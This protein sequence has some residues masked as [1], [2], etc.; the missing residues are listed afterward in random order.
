MIWSLPS[1][2]ANVI[3]ADRGF[4]PGLAAFGPAYGLPLSALAGVLER[5]FYTRAGIAQG[6]IWY[7]LQ[8][9]FISLIVGY[10][11]LW[12]A[13][14][15]L[16][17]IGPFWLPISVFLSIAVERKYLQ[18]RAR[19]SGFDGGWKWVGWGNVFS[20]VVLVGVLLLSTPFDTFQNRLALYPYRNLL[21]GTGI[22]VSAGIFVAAFVGPPVARRLKKR[23]RQ[24]TA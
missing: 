22:A 14:I 3:T 6:A 18:W 7:S 4:L 24:G 12:P 19:A 2:L 1:I 10:A 5:P 11:L 13:I 9:N 15:A 8:A 23:A 17:S 21:M 20:A 16:Y